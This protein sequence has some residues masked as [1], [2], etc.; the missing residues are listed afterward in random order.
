MDQA[1]WAIPRLRRM[2]KSTA[3]IQKPRCK[4]HA[5]WV[6]SIVLYVFVVDPRCSQDSSLI[7]ESGARAI[8]FAV[9]ECRA[10]E[11]EPPDQ[12]IE[13]VS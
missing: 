2:T 1:K 12:L 7:V 9:A 4:V 11:I 6:H 8:E 10:Q 13:W 3:M 5:V